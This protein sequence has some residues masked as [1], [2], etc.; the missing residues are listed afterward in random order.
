M[1]NLAGT[2]GKTGEIKKKCGIAS[3]HQEE[4]VPQHFKRYYQAVPLQKIKFRPSDH[5]L[6]AYSHGKEEEQTESY[7]SS[8]SAQIDT[9]H[10]K[11]R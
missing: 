6:T 9:S 3:F 7:W 10:Q 5:V 2:P 8:K 11:H 1:E 4:R